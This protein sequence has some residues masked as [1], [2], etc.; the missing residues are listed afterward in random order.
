MN[1]FILYTQYSQFLTVFRGL[2][3]KI[4]NIIIHHFNVFS[5]NKILLIYFCCGCWC[6]F[7]FFL[8]PLVYT[9]SILL[10]VS[11]IIGLIFTLKTHS[12]IYDIH[13]G[14]GTGEFVKLTNYGA[15][16]RHTVITKIMLFSMYISSKV[17]VRM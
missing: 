3:L 12:H 11:Y 14:D 8:R 9:I 2:L 6:V 1:T 7:L 15:L 16:N 4:V 5:I 17:S 13:V 10:P